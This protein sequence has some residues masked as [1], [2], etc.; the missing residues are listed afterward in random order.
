MSGLLEGQ[1]LG[2]DSEG[3]RDEGNGKREGER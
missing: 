2:A 1:S 3:S